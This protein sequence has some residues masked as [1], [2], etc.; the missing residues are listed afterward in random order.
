MADVNPPFDRSMEELCESFVRDRFDQ[1]DVFGRPDIEEWLAGQAIELRPEHGDGEHN[2]HPWLKLLYRHVQFGTQLFGHWLKDSATSFSG[3]EVPLEEENPFSGD[4]DSDVRHFV[5]LIPGMKTYKRRGKRVCEETRLYYGLNLGAIAV[6]TSSDGEERYAVVTMGANSIKMQSI[7]ASPELAVKLWIDVLYAEWLFGREKSK[8]AVITLCSFLESAVASE[9]LDAEHDFNVAVAVSVDGLKIC[10][11][12]YVCVFYDGTCFSPDRLYDAEAFRNM[13]IHLM[14]R[15]GDD[16][17][18][19]SQF[20]RL[21]CPDISIDSFFEEVA[22]SGVRCV[23]DRWSRNG[24]EF[25]RTNPPQQVLVSF[26]D[27]KVL[28]V[29]QEQCPFLALGSGVSVIWR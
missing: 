11:A 14:R 23:T 17:M 18:S 25:A 12:D 15:F 21:D 27:G 19:T 29:H 7:M 1:E 22:E 28:F 3:R 10:K 2:K 8:R 24:F 13:K 26:K 4:S 6:T 16:R 5:S 20:V 9:R